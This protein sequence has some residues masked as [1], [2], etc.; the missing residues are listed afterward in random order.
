VKSLTSQAVFRHPADFVTLAL[1]VA[2][3]TLLKSACEDGVAC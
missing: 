1:A 2:G 3:K